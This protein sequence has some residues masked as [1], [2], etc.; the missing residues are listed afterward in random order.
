[1]LQR[2]TSSQGFAT[3]EGHLLLKPIRFESKA[4]SDFCFV[5]RLIG[6]PL[7]TFPDAL[8][9]TDRKHFVIPAKQSAEPGS[10]N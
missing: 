1:L 5:V 2:V 6:K 3:N 7:R 10:Q 8:L 4:G 9:P